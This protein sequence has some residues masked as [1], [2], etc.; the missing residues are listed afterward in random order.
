V[1]GHIGGFGGFR[2]ALWYAPEDDMLVTLSVS[3]A[4]TDPNKLARQIFGALLAH[5]KQ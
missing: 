2:A 1:I 3:Q 5:Q 4:S